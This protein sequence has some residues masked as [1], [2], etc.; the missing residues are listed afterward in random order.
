VDKHGP[1]KETDA[2]K[3]VF[4]QLIY[5]LINGKTNQVEMRIP[6]NWCLYSAGP[7]ITE[8]SK[9]VP[10]LKILKLKLAKYRRIIPPYC[11][12]QVDSPFSNVEIVEM[13]DWNFADK[14]VKALVPLVPNVKSLY[15]SQIYIFLCMGVFK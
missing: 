10:G 4:S 14:D 15:V 1:I 8:I 2:F 5:N 7:I 12:K 9:M 11:L 6:L 3:K 13:R